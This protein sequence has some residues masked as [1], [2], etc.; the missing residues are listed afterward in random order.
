MTESLLRRDSAYASSV[1]HNKNKEKKAIELI[2]ENS[3]YIL[4]SK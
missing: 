3:N 2:N 1:R 4:S